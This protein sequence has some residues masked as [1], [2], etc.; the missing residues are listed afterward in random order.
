MRWE[1]K[2]WI[3]GFFYLC[4]ELTKPIQT[5]IDPKLFCKHCKQL[6]T[7]CHKHIYSDYITKKLFSIYSNKLEGPGYNDMKKEMVIAYNEKRRCNYYD[8][9]GFYDSANVDLPWCLEYHSFTIAKMIQ[10]V[11]VATKINH[12][13]REGI[14]QLLCAKKFHKAWNFYVGEVQSLRVWRSSKS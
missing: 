6:N 1:N 4:N 11:V 10:E 14:I 7:H 13:T 12:E 5:D 9:F 8:R 2:P 3:Q